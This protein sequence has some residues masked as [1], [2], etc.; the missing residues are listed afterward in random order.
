M[1][2]SVTLCKASTCFFLCQDVRAGLQEC[3]AAPEAEAEDAED[4]L[5]MILGQGL[6][7][8]LCLAGLNPPAVLE[9]H[10]ARLDV[11]GQE[12]QQ[13]LPDSHWDALLVSLKVCH[14]C[15]WRDHACRSAAAQA[16]YCAWMHASS[17]TCNARPQRSQAVKM[18]Q[19]AAATPSSMQACWS[20][21]AHM[22]AVP[23]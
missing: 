10:T 8:L 21:Q 13:P 16:P 19:A 3:L 20:Q 1:R 7:L 11:P 2:V 6:G 23:A 5:L 14:P 22:A 18:Q 12:L 9:L 17:S 15:I 4:A